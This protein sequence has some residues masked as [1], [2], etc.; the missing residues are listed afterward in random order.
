MR[1]WQQ[2]LQNAKPASKQGKKLNELHHFCT[3]IHHPCHPSLSNPSTGPSF[4]KPSTPANPA[5]PIGKASNC[6]AYAFALWNIPRAMSPITG[7]KKGI[8][9]IVWKVRLSAKWKMVSG[10]R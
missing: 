6:P 2:Y 10:L 3:K 9:F 1:N 5:P 7:A 4:P 8:W